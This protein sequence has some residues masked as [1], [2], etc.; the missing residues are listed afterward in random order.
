MIE[1]STLNQKV[2]K[3]QPQEPLQEPTSKFLKISIKFDSLVQ[4]ICYSSF[5]E[6]KSHF[7]E[8]ICTAGSLV[9][10]ASI[11]HHVLLRKVNLLS[12]HAPVTKDV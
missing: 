7:L 10:S 4:R 3:K 9:N 2:S 6:K 1:R 12:L 5:C 8:K 11:G